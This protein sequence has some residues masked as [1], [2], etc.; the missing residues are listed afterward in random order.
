[1]SQVG[2][3]CSRV[4]VLNHGCGTFLGDTNEGIERYNDLFSDKELAVAGTGEVKIENLKLLDKEAVILL[5]L[6]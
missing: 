1:M 2:K 4:M 3:L 6:F 5:Y